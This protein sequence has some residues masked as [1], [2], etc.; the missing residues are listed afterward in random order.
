MPSTT[1]M[2]IPVS[3][4]SNSPWLNAYNAAEPSTTAVT[5]WSCNCRARLNRLRADSSIFGDR[6]FCHGALS[7]SGNNANIRQF[8]VIM[9]V[10]QTVANH[11]RI[12][13]GKAHIVGIDFHLAFF[14][15]VQQNA[16]LHRRRTALVQ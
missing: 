15:L 5:S 4:R 6:D 3:N 1:G 14:R 8:A 10:I 9:G 16:Q 7:I 2:T 11:K 12:A 13:N